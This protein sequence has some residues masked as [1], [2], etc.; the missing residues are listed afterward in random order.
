MDVFVYYDD[1]FKTQFA[2]KAKTRAAA[3]MAIVEEMYSEKATL[4]TKIDLNIVA[5]EHMAKDWGNTKWK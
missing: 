3:V 2:D 4:K 5:I 1:L